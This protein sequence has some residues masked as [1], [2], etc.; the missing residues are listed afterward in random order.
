[1]SKFC[2]MW[3]CWPCANH[4]PIGICNSTNQGKCWRLIIWLSWTFDSNKK[5]S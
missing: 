5:K 4:L 1:M 2:G 3:G